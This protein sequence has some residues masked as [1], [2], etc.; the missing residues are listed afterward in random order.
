MSRGVIQ[1]T[2]AMTREVFGALRSVLLMTTPDLVIEGES[3]RLE[4]I[5]SL[6]SVRS[7][8]E[9]SKNTSNSVQDNLYRIANYFRTD[10]EKPRTA[11]FY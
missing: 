9:R 10:T 4:T 1:K 8:F 2:R 3:V 11:L 5:R 6:D 7:S